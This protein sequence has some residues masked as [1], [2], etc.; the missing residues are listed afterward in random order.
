MKSKQGAKGNDSKVDGVHDVARNSRVR[1]LCESRTGNRGPAQLAAVRYLQNGRWGF[2]QSPLRAGQVPRLRAARAPV[3]APR[4][5]SRRQWGDSL[6]AG[7]RAT[8]E[9][10]P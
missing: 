8:A 5:C 4:G 1:R 7:R 3:A 9:A 10:T 6:G 2:G